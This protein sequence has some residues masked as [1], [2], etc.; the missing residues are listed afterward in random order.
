MKAMKYTEKME[1]RY[2]IGQCIASYRSLTNET[3][4]DLAKLLKVSRQ[5][6]SNIESGI[7]NLPLDK[8][9][10]IADHYHIPVSRLLGDESTASSESLQM[11]VYKEVSTM[12]PVGSAIVVSRHYLEKQEYKNRK[13]EIVNKTYRL[14]N[15][16][17]GL[18]SD[19]LYAVEISDSSMTLNIPTGSKA[20]VQKIT[21]DSQ[22]PSF[23]KPTLV[24][25]RWLGVAE[26][27]EELGYAYEK[28]VKEHPVENVFVSLVD[29]TKKAK[30]NGQN[31]IQYTMANETLFAS[32]E[33][34]KEMCAGIVKK[35][36]I[37][38]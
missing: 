5:Y 25:L 36:V 1:K 27:P 38:Y 7:S 33:E 23:Q 29:P 11:T 4:Q 6:I 10:I 28:Y 30:Y 12:Q 24:V 16:I 8:A 20:I 37:D 32:V 9:K 35:V 21:N 15:N 26:A 22:K 18:A 2:K 31:L 34:L 19:D 13:K 3:Q 17:F 14:D